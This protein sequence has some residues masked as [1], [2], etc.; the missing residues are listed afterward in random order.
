MVTLMCSAKCESH[1]KGGKDY[2]AGEE[3]KNGSHECNP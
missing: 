1:I 2:E 3:K